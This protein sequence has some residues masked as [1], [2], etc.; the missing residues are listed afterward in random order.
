M[1]LASSNKEA[2][3]SKVRSADGPLL[4]L[5]SLSSLEVS[6]EESEEELSEVSSSLEEGEVEEEVDGPQPKRRMEDRRS[7]GDFDM[8]FI[9][10]VLGDLP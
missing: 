10:V 7:K 3:S 6:S 9:L 1:K 5:D 8:N 4:E 2:A